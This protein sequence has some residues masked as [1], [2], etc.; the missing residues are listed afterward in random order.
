MR[1]VVFVCCILAALSAPAAS[2]ECALA[3]SCIHPVPSE[4][5]PRFSA[6]EILKMIQC[7]LTCISE[8]RARTPCLLCNSAWLALLCN[9]RTLVES[10]LLLYVSSLRAIFM[11]CTYFLFTCSRFE[12]GR[13]Q[14]Q[15][16]N[17]QVSIYFVCVYC[18]LQFFIMVQF[19]MFTIMQ[20]EDCI[21]TVISVQLSETMFDHT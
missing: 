14:Q 20:P 19:Y 11:E 8:V 21:I 6:D 4:A 2:E 1:A 17:V 5:P 9:A 12:C 10:A 13:S 18:L 7:H 16:I 3:S 15:P